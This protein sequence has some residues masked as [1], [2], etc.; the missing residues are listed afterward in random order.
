MGRVTV[1]ALLLCARGALAEPRTPAPHWLNGRL[2]G[3]TAKLVVRYPLA[4]AGPSNANSFDLVLPDNGV[5][6]G[7]VV[8]ADGHRHRLAFDAADHGRAQFDATVETPAGPHRRWAVAVSSTFSTSVTVDIAAA[9]AA[10]LAIDLEVEAPTCFSHGTRYAAVAPDWRASIDHALR[11][12]TA[13][14]DGCVARPDEDG[15]PGSAKLWIAFPSDRGGGRPPGE[16]RVVLRG[17]R[18]DVEHGHFARVEVNLASEL[19][20]VPADLHTVFVI[21]ASRSLEPDQREAQA[22]LVQ[23]YA[24]RAPGTQIQIVAFART[25]HALLPGWTR[26]GDAKLAGLATI[27]AANGSNVDTGLVEAAAWLARTGGT[28]RVVL[29]GDDRLGKRVAALDPDALRGV[30]PAGTLVHVVALA[31]APT[32][33]R[34]DQRA[35]ETIARADDIAFAQLARATEGLAARATLVD[36][37]IDATKLV[38][39]ISLDQVRVHATGWSEGRI[40]ADEPHCTGDL[41]QGSACAWFGVADRDAT[42]TPSVVPTIVVDGLMWNHPVHETVTPDAGQRER[43]ARMLTG[44]MANLGDAE[45]DL[46]VVAHAVNPAWVLVGAWG[47]ADGYGDLGASEL[48]SSGCGCDDAGTI[49]GVGVGSSSTVRMTGPS[50]AAQLERA[51]AACH[52]DAR[53]GITIELTDQEIVDV[54]VTAPRAELRDCVTEAVWNTALFVADPKPHAVETL[55]LGA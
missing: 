45:H 15:G 39:P 20:D 7:A 32:T 50:I 24:R 37:R 3:I 11:T 52:V 51:T 12:T 23:S 22:K 33:E 6:T 2:D 16:P 47:G 38:R 34:T 55:A 9:H 27:A 8:V 30:L 1:F 36:G 42:V 46:Q 14:P 35:P 54:A 53:V 4:A 5:V 21:D 31:P 44:F 49:Q 10:M 40:E 28:R 17:E 43:L 26:A 41:A 48:D 29:I 18:V 25:A 19:A 13:T